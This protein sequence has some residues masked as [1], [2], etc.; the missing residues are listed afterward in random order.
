MSDSELASLQERFGG[1]GWAMLNAGPQSR[2]NVIGVPLPCSGKMTIP[3]LLKAFEKGADGVVICGCPEAECKQLE[4]NLRASKRA[5]AVEALVE[6]I[7]VGPGRVVMVTKKPD[8]ID[9]AIDGIQ[10]LQ[11]GPHAQAIPEKNEKKKV[12]K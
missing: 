11:A 7:G 2:C 1:N 12:R 10:R 6:E 3:Y 4:G 9:K 5:Q 8:Q